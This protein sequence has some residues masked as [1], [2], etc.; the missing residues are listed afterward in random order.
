MAT[1]ALLKAIPSGIRVPRNPWIWNH[2]FT[3]TMIV[4]TVSVFVTGWCAS[5]LLSRFPIAFGPSQKHYTCVPDY[6]SGKIVTGVRSSTRFISS[7]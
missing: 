6:A 5:I 4:N 1:Q 7:I 2:F 3:H